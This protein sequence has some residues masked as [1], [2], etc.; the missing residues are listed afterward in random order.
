MLYDFLCVILSRV[1]NS[2]C[3]SVQGVTANKHGCYP[4]STLCVKYDRS[5]DDGITFM[6]TLGKKKQTKTMSIDD[7]VVPNDWLL[8]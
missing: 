2:N 7:N 1:L 8:A 5:D 3:W 6:K 4:L